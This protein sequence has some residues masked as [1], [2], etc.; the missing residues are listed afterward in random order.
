MDALGKQQAIRAQVPMSEM[1][2]YAPTL[3]SITSDRGSYTM[4]FS[5]YDEVP[6]QIQE[7]L[8]AAAKAAKAEDH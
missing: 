1:L 4:A 3:K 7:K 8:V 6:G 2:E 5:H